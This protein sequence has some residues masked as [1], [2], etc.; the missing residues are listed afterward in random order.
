MQEETRK[1]RQEVGQER[2]EGSKREMEEGR[3]IRFRK[4]QYKRQEERME[5]R[6]AGIRT[7]FN[8]FENRRPYHAGPEGYSSRRYSTNQT[9]YS[10]PGP[11]SMY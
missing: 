2:Q 7:L 5:G 10:C 6:K 11:G 1:A 8:H 4:R 9:T 3:K